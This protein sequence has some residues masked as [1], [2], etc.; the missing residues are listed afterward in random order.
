MMFVVVYSM[1]TGLRFGCSEAL[2]MS[3]GVDVCFHWRINLFFCSGQASV[4]LAV[5]KD[6]KRRVTEILSREIRRGSVWAC[7]SNFQRWEFR[8]EKWADLKIKNKIQLCL[9][10]TNTCS[11]LIQL[12]G[13]RFDSSNRSGVYCFAGGAEEHWCWIAGRPHLNQCTGL[14]SEKKERERERGR[15]R[16]RD[17]ERERAGSCSWTWIKWFCVNIGIS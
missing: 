9:I 3:F 17:R 15:E 12:V 1:F 13:A 6:C 5:R 7:L 8:I 16:E 10:C 4:A 14:I 11:E 2:C